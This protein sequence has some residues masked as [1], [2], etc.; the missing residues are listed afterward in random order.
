[1]VLYQHQNNTGDL[2]PEGKL[3]NRLDQSHPLIILAK[4]I[5]WSAIELAL[6]TFFSQSKGRPSLSL[7]LLVGL[8]ILKFVYNLSDERVVEQWKENSYFQAFTGQNSLLDN[9]PCDSSELSRFR[10]RIG[11]KGCAIIFAESVRIHG[12]LAYEKEVIGDT[13]V[14]EKYTK[15]PTDV[16]LNLD[17]ISLCLRI[18]KFMDVKLRRT[19]KKKVKKIKNI[20]NFS[21]GKLGVKLKRRAVSQLRTCANAILRDLQRKL[22]ENVMEEDEVKRFFDNAT[23]AVNQQKN[24]K[25]KIYSLFEP[26]IKRIAKGKAHKKYEFG[27]KVSFMIGKNNGVILGALSFHNN[28]YDGDTIESALDQLATL[29]NGYKPELFIGDR[30]YRGRPEVRGV[31]VLTPSDPD[32]KN[33]DLDALKKNKTRHC[34]R[35]SIEPIIGH[36]KHDHRLGRNWL[37]G[38]IGDEINPFWSATAFNL[39]KYTGIITAAL[40]NPFKNGA[41]KAKKAVSKLIGY[42]F[43]RSVMATAGESLFDRLTACPGV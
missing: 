20:V 5:C 18:A 12:K 23:K 19:Y 40:F 13:T 37:K 36:V 8:Q 27:N 42:P 41:K 35:S 29:H 24:D 28:P 38:E 32:S 4:V 3:I 17:A 11:A 43:R 30:G 34:R 31:K 2:F 26:Q 1:M 22:P 10:K 6:A 16:R 25:N 15:F 7:R 33:L 39:K 9:I 21:K 14:Q